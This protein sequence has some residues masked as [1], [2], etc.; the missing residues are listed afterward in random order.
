[1]QRRNLAAIALVLLL[2]GSGSW[3]VRAQDAGDG[4]RVPI[5]SAPTFITVPEEE[6]LV[7]WVRSVAQGKA[8]A[9]VLVQTVDGWVQMTPC[10]N[11]AVVCRDVVIRAEGTERGDIFYLGNE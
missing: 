5:V 6:P 4:V 1:M 8:T 11:A 9:V 10:D 3:A 7:L 2:A